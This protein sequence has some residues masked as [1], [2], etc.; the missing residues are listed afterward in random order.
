MLKISV[1]ITSIQHSSHLISVLEKRKKVIYAMD[2]GS[3][4]SIYMYI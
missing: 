1:R 4:I 3:F 2:N